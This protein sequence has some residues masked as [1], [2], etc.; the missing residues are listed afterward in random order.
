MRKMDS[1]NLNRLSQTWLAPQYVAPWNHHPS[2]RT[3]S[4]LS[5]PL[6]V[7]N[8]RKKV[9]LSNAKQ[10]LLTCATIVLRQPSTC[11]LC[12]SWKVTLVTILANQQSLSKSLWTWNRTL[13]KI[14]LLMFKRHRRPSSWNLGK[15][16]ITNDQLLHY[17]WKSLSNHLWRTS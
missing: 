5:H 9:N 2:T 1:H 12:F 16:Q 11:V 13:I 8:S 15:S 7:V 4:R 6:W 3:R 10:P 14:R 17:Y